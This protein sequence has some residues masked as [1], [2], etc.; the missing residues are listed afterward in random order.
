MIERFDKQ[1]SSVKMFSSLSE[2]RRIEI[3]RIMK[4]IFKQECVT[5]GLARPAVV[6]PLEAPP[7]SRVEIPIFSWW[8]N[9]TG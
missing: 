1:W 3:V 6:L 9:W 5:L 7:T 8:R 4:Y 2:K